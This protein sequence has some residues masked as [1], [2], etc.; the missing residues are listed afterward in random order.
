MDF[1][2]QLKSSVDIV[3]TIGEYVRLKRVGSTPRYMGLCPFHN[4]KTPSFSVHMSHQ[5][6]KCFGCGVG[7]DV[8]KFVMEMERI[9]FV[10]ALKL[11]A[12]RNGLTMPKREYSDPESKLRGALIEMHETSAAVFQKNLA[13]P[14]GAEARNYLSGRGVSPE[15]ITEFGLGLSDASGQQVIRMLDSRFAPEQ[16][17]VSGLVLKR[18]DGSGFF[19]RFRG[20][21]MFPIHNESGKIIGFGG[22]AL[23]SGDEPKYLNSPETALYHKSHVLYNLHRAKDAVRKADCA[24]L[25]EGYMD[26]IGVYSAGVRNVVASCGTALTN[27]QVR[28]LKKHSGRMVVNF[29]PDAAGANAAERSIQMLLD[30]GF[31]VR[32][33]ELEGEL[34]PDEYVQREGA[35]RYRDRLE[36]APSYFHWLADRARKKFDMRTVEGRLQGFKFVAPAIQRIADRLER[37]AVANDVADYLGVDE[38]LVRD[39]FSR[40]TAEQRSMSRGPV[41]PPNERL[42]LNALLISEEARAET[43]PQLRALPAVQQFVTKRVFQAIFA[44]QADGGSFRFAD[45]EGRLADADRDLLSAAV[46]ADEELEEEKALDQARDCVRRLLAHHPMAELEVLRARTRAAEREGNR[47]E[48]LRLNAEFQRVRLEAQRQYESSRRSRT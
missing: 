47:E 3:K 44:M 36:K 4:E 9:S 33:L 25:V 20:R 12:E 46:F 37:F 48:V 34:D 21:L 7:G 11:L 40:G 8:L 6:F 45:L 1:V 29:D 38:K 41:V 39:H 24:V 27:T 23:R 14:Q 16:L 35:E 17:E 28:A 19:D 43:T 15:Q 26:V 31:Q 10:E 5:F 18:Q 2:E 22:R 13:G 32:V 30:E 42:L